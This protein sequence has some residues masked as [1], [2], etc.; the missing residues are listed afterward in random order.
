[1]DHGK[2]HD[3]TGILKKTSICQKR[4]SSFT[5]YI[6]H[7]YFPLWN[8]FSSQFPNLKDLSFPKLLFVVVLAFPFYRNPELY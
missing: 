4:L 6:F 5:E 2:W 8:F 7:F 3:D 1:M